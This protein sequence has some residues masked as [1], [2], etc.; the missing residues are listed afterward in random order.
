MKKVVIIGY[1]FV[2]PEGISS[3]RDLW[4]ALEQ[5]KD[6]VSEIPNSRIDKKRFL[7]LSKK[8]LENHIAFR[9]ELFQILKYL[10]STLFQYKFKRSEQN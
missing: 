7:H 1:S 3:D 4:Q 2:L 8:K 5:S 6:L 9:L 10:I